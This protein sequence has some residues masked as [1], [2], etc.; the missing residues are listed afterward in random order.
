MTRAEAW[1]THAAALLVGGTGVVY[2]WMRY[3]AEPVDE[4]ALVSHPL[5]PAFQSAHILVAPLLVFAAG[6]LWR[7]HI[8]GRL[9]A[10]N[11]ARRPSGVALLAL[12]VPM[13]VSG[14]L[15]QTASADLGREVALWVHGLSGALWVL[16][17][18]LHLLAPR[19]RGVSSS[20]EVRGST[21]PWGESTAESSR[22]A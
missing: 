1:F 3:F 10:G 7:E 18:G 22:R 6:L 16:G 20:G 12:L 11:G 21:G 15:V 13:V 19:R 2:A 5:E 17:Y 9:R 14:Y 4:L 8:L